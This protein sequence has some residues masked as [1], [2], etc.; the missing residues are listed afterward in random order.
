MRYPLREGKNVLSALP[1]R[2]RGLLQTGFTLRALAGA[3]TQLQLSRVGLTLPY[4][5][6]VSGALTKRTAGGHPGYPSH[7]KNPQYK[8]VLERK[9]T[10]RLALKGAAELAWNAK[11]LW[12]AD[13]VFELSAEAIVAASGPYSYGMAYCE[14]DDVERELPDL[15][16]LTPAGAYTVLV[17]SYEREEGAYS[18]TVEAS[19]PVR[20]SSIPQEGAG[21]Y[22][23]TIAGRWYVRDGMG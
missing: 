14:V 2:D 3:G 19:A 11:L 6:E 9:G 12:G 17:S 15:K 20:L 7:S 1:S 16:E 4:T 10:L 8:L 18:L 21:M 23:R 22:A 13:R 5:E